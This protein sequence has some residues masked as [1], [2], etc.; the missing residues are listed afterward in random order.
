MIK[1]A[2]ALKTEKE[3][4]FCKICSFLTEHYVGI[5]DNNQS[6][7]VLMRKN[8]DGLFIYRLGCHNNLDDLDAAVFDETDEHIICVSEDSGYIIALK[9]D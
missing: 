4:D 1:V 2:R 8:D 3:L 5:Y 7:F 6:E 9:D